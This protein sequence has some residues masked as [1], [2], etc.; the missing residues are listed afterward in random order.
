MRTPNDYSEV[1]LEKLKEQGVGVKQARHLSIE[2]PIRNR[3]IALPV[4]FTT[5]IQTKLGEIEEYITEN[6]PED[7]V[8]GAI[9]FIAQ[10]VETK[11]SNKNNLE[12]ISVPDLRYLTEYGVKNR[13]EL[14][15]IIGGM[16]LDK[17]AMQVNSTS[18]D[19][20]LNLETF[21]AMNRL[22]ER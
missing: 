15:E 6:F 3:G 20:D 17:E 16:Y 9:N 8:Q 5:E 7:E 18:I 12:Y 2:D 10:F 14:E 13:E 22:D 21:T 19:G 11:K 1:D 4:L